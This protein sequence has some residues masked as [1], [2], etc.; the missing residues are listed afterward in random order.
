MKIGRKP[1][2][3]IG[4]SVYLH[5]S[6]IAGSEHEGAVAKAAPSCS[7]FVWTVAKVNKK[8]SAVT[9]TH[10]PDFLT[11]DEPRVG[12]AIR[13]T[14]EGKVVAQGA[15]SDPWIY[16]H[17]WQMVREDFDGFSVE[18]SKARS[19]AWESLKGVDKSRIGKQSYWVSKVVP[20][21]T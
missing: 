10:S 2:K 17:K 6:A 20:R 14:A 3:R 16:H 21:L 4:G 11:A 13:V 15:A 8:T 18:E 1:G 19:A 9:F 7:S 5:V 12:A